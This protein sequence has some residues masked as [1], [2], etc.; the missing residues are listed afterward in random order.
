MDT[1]YK[2]SAEV[3]AHKR[4]YMRKYNATP[5]GAEYNRAHVRAWRRANPGKAIRSKYRTTARQQ[6]YREIALNFLEERDG[7]TCPV[8]EE[9][10][11]R[12]AIVRSEKVEIDHITPIRLGGDNKTG[13]VRMVH[14]RCNIKNSVE[15]RQ[16]L[17]G[18]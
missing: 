4:E 5:K 9:L 8:C 6:D 3:R 16:Q 7:L 10:L 2:Q 15:I 14:S 1:P 12:S 18:Y 17:H 13:N 11:D